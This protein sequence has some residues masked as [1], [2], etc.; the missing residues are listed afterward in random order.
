MARVRISK[1]CLF[2]FV[3]LATIGSFTGNLAFAD[4]TSKTEKDE[5][6]VPNQSWTT[7]TKGQC[8]TLKDE[9]SG[10]TQYGFTGKKYR[11]ENGECQWRNYKSN[12]K[13]QKVSFNDKKL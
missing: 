13:W 4:P 12:D 11:C 3:F 9:Y 5:T 1:I 7:A 2:L 10:E 6:A 8:N